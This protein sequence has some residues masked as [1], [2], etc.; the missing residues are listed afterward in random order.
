MKSIIFI[1]TG[2]LSDISDASTIHSL[3]LVREAIKSNNKVFLFGKSTTLSVRD[4]F[5]ELIGDYAFSKNLYIYISKIKSSLHNVFCSLI[6]NTY[7]IFKIIFDIDFHGVIHSRSIYTSASLQLFKSLISPRVKHIHEWHLINPHSLVSRI[8]KFLLQARNIEHIFITKSLMD[9]CIA[10]AK[11]P[12]LVNFRVVSDASLTLAEAKSILKP[13]QS[14]L[15]KHVKESLV[16]SR[17]SSVCYSGSQQIGKGADFVLDVARLLP[18]FDFF[19]IGRFQQQ[20]IDIS[21]PN[22]K[23]LGFHPNHVAICLLELFDIML[24][25]NK[26]HQVHKKSRFGKYTSPLKLF[27]YMASSK[28]IICSNLPVLREILSSNNAL[29]FDPEDKLSCRDRLLL[30]ESLLCDKNLDTMQYNLSDLH[31]QHYSW[32]SRFIDIFGR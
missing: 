28:I 14:S 15:I 25:P 20:F 23:F 30:A 27:E 31:S 26:F 32:R 11:K 22:V 18:N 3:N 13:N 2:N 9:D 8:E 5:L 21:P 4:S 24:L 16:D 17:R 29:F 1:T 7:Q 10:L 6:F 19:M 12:R